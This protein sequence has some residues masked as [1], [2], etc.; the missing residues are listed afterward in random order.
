M[1][2]TPSQL[3][4]LRLWLEPRPREGALVRIQVRHVL[5]GETVYFRDWY[6]ARAYL[7]AKLKGAKGAGPEDGTSDGEGA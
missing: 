1:P 6:Q 3:F 7:M 5:S 4:L 2:S